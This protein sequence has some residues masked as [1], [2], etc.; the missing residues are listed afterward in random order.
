M[1]PDN[2]A[3]DQELQAEIARREAAEEALREQEAELRRALDQVD[4]ERRRFKELFRAAPVPYLI[5]DIEG[6]IREANDAASALL[7][8]PRGRLPGRNLAEYAGPTRQ[9]KAQLQRLARMDVVD[10][11]E[12]ELKVAGD[13]A[14]PVMVSGI[15]ARGPDG[16]AMEVRWV[17]MDVR[18]ARATSEREQAL[19]REQAAR[20]TLERVAERAAFLSNASARLMGV[21]N[22]DAVWQLAAALAQSY[23]SGVAL[24][25]LRGE[26]A[27]LLEVRAVSGVAELRQRL[28]PLQRRVLNLRDDR[29]GEHCFPLTTMRTALRRREATIAS[30]WEGE[31]VP[32]KHGGTLVVPLF[33]DRG[34]AGLEIVWLNAGA[35]VGQELLMHRTLAERVGLALQGAM[36]FEEVLRARRRAEEAT[37]AEADF[38]AMVSHEL[39]TPLT[40]ITSYAE[41]LSDHA[42]DLPGKLARYAQQIAGAARHQRQLVEQIL[43]YKQVQREGLD[44]VAEE[45]LDFRDVAQF[46]VSMVRPQAEGRPV[47]L[48]AIVPATPIHGVCDPGKVRQVLANLLSNAVRHTAAGHVREDPRLPVLPDPVPGED[49]AVHDHVDARREDLDGGEGAAQVEEPVGAAEGDGDHGAGEDDGL[50]GSRPGP[51]RRRCPPWCRCRG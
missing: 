21:L 19:Q 17:I 42:D 39:R 48:S 11:W 2:D 49:A 12:A 27:D 8:T 16:E 5:T 31:L 25:E 33:T 10:E 32:G 15:P 23:A 3:R 26:A 24:L 44:A 4:Q 34:I 47:E 41:L 50:A 9:L 22:P 45:E 37:A 20:A 40:A 14:I 6:H 43:N 13:E 46:A 30:S 38:L 29:A 35:R 36:L 51:G 7:H 18:Q 1:Q 28:D